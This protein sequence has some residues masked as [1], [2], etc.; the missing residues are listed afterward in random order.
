MKLLIIYSLLTS[1]LS[2]SSLASTIPQTPFAVS[3]NTD[4][5]TYESSKSILSPKLKHRIDSLREKW[6]VPGLTIGLAASPEF[7]AS[8][9]GLDS[10]AE[11]EW[12]LE[13]ATFG[14]ADRHGNPVDAD[15]QFGIASNSKLFAVSSIGLLIS[16]GTILPNGGTLDWETKIKDILPEWKL[17]DGYATEHVNLIDLM[18]MRSGLPRHDFIEAGQSPAT[19][20]K[21]LRYL[22]PSAGL[23]EHWQYNNQHYITLDHIIYTLTNLTLP[24]YAQIH[25]FDP[26]GLD[27]TTY[28]ATKA[29]ESGH[30][31]DGHIHFGRNLTACQQGWEY[32]ERVGWEDCVGKA[33]SFGW[34][35]NDDALPEAGAGGVITTATDLSK[36]LKELLKPS[37]L[38]PDVIEKA[39]TAFAVRTARPQ[40]PEYGIETYGLGQFQYTYRGHTIHGHTG[41]VP[42]QLSITLRL[43]DIGVG[44][45]IVLNDEDFGGSLQSVIGNEILDSLLGLDPINWEQRIMSKAFKPSQY[46]D[47]PTNPRAPPSRSVI[48]GR[49]HA[50]AYGDLE[51]VKVEIPKGESSTSPSGI[52]DISPLSMTEFLSTTRT[53]LNISGPIYMAE[54]ER[55]FVVQV[56]F[57]HFDGPVFNWTAVWF[58]D[59]LN[60]KDRVDGKLVTLQAIGTAVISESERGFG[61][62]GNFWGKGETAKDSVV[63]EEG[64]QAASEVWFAKQ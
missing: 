1:L 21:N 2:I 56:Y 33:G 12:T 59:R 11:K 60:E 39:T 42:G 54:Y 46:P 13:T 43:P 57:T 53:P 29:A 36:W 35:A 47:V 50:P 25:I 49:Y 38:P 15:T 14:V 6:G 64:V 24:Q 5:S 20:V 45:F 41:S 28:N 48:E 37:V 34:W 19:V 44:F 7:T 32:G 51:L 40:Y 31:S 58:A 63:S 4:Q 9:F 8:H 62:F 3:S 10:T 61:L 30:R 52:E 17:M 55:R 26:L 18:S 27:S 22:K 23:R 16:N